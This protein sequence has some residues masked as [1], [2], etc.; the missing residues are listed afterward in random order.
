MMTA[1]FDFS[2][3]VIPSCLYTEAQA[4][5][6][7]ATLRISTFFIIGSKLNG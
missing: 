1:I 3:D 2:L 7:I 6:N 4:E 5:T